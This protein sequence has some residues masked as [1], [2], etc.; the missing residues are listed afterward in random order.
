MQQE[1]QALEN[2]GTWKISDLPP[3]KKA[4][5]CKWVFKIKY[6]FDGTV[7]RHNAWLVVFGNYPVE[8]IDFTETF[9][10]VAKMVTVRMFLA[11]AAAKQWELY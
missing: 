3:H 7:E 6:N 5:G 2:N 10:H 11:V 1:I 4:L 8:G 9:A